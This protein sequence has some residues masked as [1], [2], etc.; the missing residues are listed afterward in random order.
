MS[1]I[2]Y[3]YTINKLI[4]YA[5]DVYSQ[6]GEDGILEEIFKKL[7]IPVGQFVEFGAW[8]GKHLSNTYNLLENRNWSGLY[9][10]YEDDKYKELEKLNVVYKDR[11][12]TVKNKVDITGENSLDNI[13][14]RHP[15][16]KQDF[17]L[18]S[19][20]IDSYDLEIWESLKNYQPKVVII[21]VNSFVYPPLALRHGQIKFE[22]GYIGSDQGCSFSAVVEV[23]KKK[24]YN[25]VCHTGNC[26]LVRSDLVGQLGLNHLDING[27][28]LLFSQKW[29]KKL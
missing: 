26:I 14:H 29:E 11:I 28:N 15:E 3:T 18:L 17:D 10:E 6:N 23:S 1:E 16:I 12:I 9:I 19:I 27:P 20:D 4:N 21:E 2:T 7:N 8:D 25:V 22:G 5:K 13:L 24:N